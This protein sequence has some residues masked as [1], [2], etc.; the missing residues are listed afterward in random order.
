MADLGAPPAR[1][2]P[3]PWPPSPMAHNFLNFTQFFAK[4][5]KIICWPPPE[6]W[7]PLL[8]GILDPPLITIIFH[9]NHL[10]VCVCVCVVSAY[11]SLVLMIGQ[12]IKG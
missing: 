4:F 3:P 6:G 9:T 11:I 12:L 5:G 8:R 2:P 1:G 7:H 10:C